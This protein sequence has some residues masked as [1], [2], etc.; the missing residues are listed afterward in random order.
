MGN[1][2]MGKLLITASGRIW[3]NIVQIQ[4]EMTERS[5]RAEVA[6]LLEQ[7]DKAA[8]FELWTIKFWHLRL[9]ET[10][11]F[12]NKK[13]NM[14]IEVTAEERRKLHFEEEYKET[15]SHRRLERQ[16]GKL[17]PFNWGDPTWFQPSVHSELLVTLISNTSHIEML[18]WAFLPY[19]FFSETPAN[20]TLLLNAQSLLCLTTQPLELV[21]L[22]SQCC[23][24]SYLAE[25]KI[26]CI[27]EILFI[28]DSPFTFPREK[29]LILNFISP[30]E[31]YHFH[32][33][34]TYPSNTGA[35]GGKRRVGED[36]KCDR[37]LW[38]LI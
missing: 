17:G 2:S 28:F 27:K 36:R 30:Q 13:G 23:A 6:F 21:T 37:E 20:E 10:I 26:S 25:W 12:G 16:T 9:Y 38:E 4:W 34:D 14:D 5:L 24:L 8:C 31:Q 19:F 15:R 35:G 33:A 29:V 3:Q 22:N 11:L 32:S 1:W 7:T 18:W